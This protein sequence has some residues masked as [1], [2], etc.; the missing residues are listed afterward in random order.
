M[1][2]AIALEFAKQGAKMVLCDLETKECREIAKQVN[3]LGS[4]ALSIKCDV[5]KKS[6]VKR[7]VA[8]TIQKFK[9][10]D[11]LINNAGKTLTNP[12]TKIKEKEWNEIIDTNL[13]GVFLFSREVSNHM[14]NKKKGKIININSVA[15]EVGFLNSSAYCAS[16]GGV[17]NLTKELAIE[18]SPHHINVNGI[19]PGIIPTNRTEKMLKNE[20]HQKELLSNIP[21]NRFGTPENIADAVVF[22]ASADSDFIT[23]HNLAVD[24]GWLIY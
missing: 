21:L 9:K 13:K 19:A 23:G 1:G 12:I 22:L 6:D 3:N 8:K 10:I 14:I 11:I 15:G 2:K 4:K 5:T 17:V 20:K 7:V 24:G 18:L 16:K